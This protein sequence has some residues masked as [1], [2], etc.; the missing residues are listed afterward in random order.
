[1]FSTPLDLLKALTMNSQLLVAFEEGTQKVQTAI[2]G[3]TPAQLQLFPVPGTWSI[4]QIVVHLAD[5]DLARSDRMK[6]IIAM[7]KPILQA[8][9]ES[10]FAQRLFYHEQSVEDS[11]AIMELD[12]RQMGRI[13]R[14]LPESA[15]ARTGMHSESGELSLAQM[16]DRAIR[17]V[18]HH[19]KFVRDKRAL[20]EAGR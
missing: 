13:L 7:D 10:R 15:F 18:D 17:H 9:D 20:I 14:N 3:L 4:H 5:A 11:L 19:L 6:R 1:M 2:A 12:R 16:V 8:W